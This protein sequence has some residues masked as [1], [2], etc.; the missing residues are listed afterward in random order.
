MGLRYRKS[1]RLANGVRLNVGTRR[2]SLSLGGPGTTVNV[3]GGGTRATFG[4]P[5]TGLSYVTKTRSNSDAAGI[6]VLVLGVLCVLGLVL[7]VLSA[8][9]SDDSEQ[10]GPK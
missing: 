10:P 2:S 7:R 8:I 3:S 5:G 4:L 1:V 9:F 6:A